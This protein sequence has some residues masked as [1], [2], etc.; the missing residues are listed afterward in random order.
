MH[1]F[2]A[3]LPLGTEL[4]APHKKCRF[5]L[6]SGLTTGVF[7]SWA[8]FETKQFQPFFNFSFPS[9]G[10][11]GILHFG[12]SSYWDAVQRT[13]LQPTGFLPPSATSAA[14]GGLWNARCM[15]YFGA[16]HTGV[17]RDSA[18]LQRE[19]S[20]NLLYKDHLWAIPLNPPSHVVD[21][22]IGFRKCGTSTPSDLT[23]QKF[24]IHIKFR[25]LFF[26]P[27]WT[28]TSF[29]SKP[30]PNS[31]FALLSYQ[32]PGN[33]TANSKIYLQVHTIKQQKTEDLLAVFPRHG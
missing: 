19:N 30:E 9:S 26:Y 31:Y 2:S 25:T 12:A 8:G 20:P 22:S 28:I 11:I 6:L 24:L 1:L 5:L 17:F 4:F 23:L 18:G 29:S 13:F 10:W 3:Q 7:A 33:A 15:R 16:I 27:I 14:A 32:R 21:L